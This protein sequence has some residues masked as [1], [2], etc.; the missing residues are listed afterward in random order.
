MPSPGSHGGFS[1][2]DDASPTPVLLPGSPL[3]PVVSGTTPEVDPLVPVAGSPVSVAVVATVAVAD[4]SVPVVME[5]VIVGSFVVVMP[6]ESDTE[7]V[8]VVVGVSL[9]PV[10]VDGVSVA[11]PTVAPVEPCVPPALASVPA[12]ESPHP[13]RPYTTT[14]PPNPIDTQRFMQPC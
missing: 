8:G 6:I 13:A 10:I 2:V 5:P 12:V 9:V 11:L 7:L 3:L 14:Q 4:G 1:P